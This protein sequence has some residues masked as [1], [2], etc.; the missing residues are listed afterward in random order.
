MRQKILW[1]SNNGI[2]IIK[3]AE[4]GKEEYY[5]IEAAYH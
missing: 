1:T 5:G 4:S 2:G 3:A